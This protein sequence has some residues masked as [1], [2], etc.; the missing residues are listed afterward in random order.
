MTAKNISQAL[1][2]ATAAAHQI[3]GALMT[4][5]ARVAADRLAL[6]RDMLIAAAEAVTAATH[7][8]KARI[9]PC[10][11]CRGTGAVQREPWRCPACGGN[12]YM[13]AN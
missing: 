12:G 10:A 9:Q 11:D 1:H 5:D 7:A 13:T 4:D 3:S 6:A 2:E 8:V